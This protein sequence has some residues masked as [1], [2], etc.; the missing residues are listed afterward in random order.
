MTPENRKKVPLSFLLASHRSGTTLLR[1]C[2]GSHSKIE[3]LD[4]VFVGYRQQP[5][6]FF[7]FHKVLVKK[8]ANWAIPE[9]ESQKRLYHEYTSY[10]RGLYNPGSNLIVDVKYSHAHRLN[11]I[12]HRPFDVPNLL[13]MVMNSEALIIHLVRKN[14]LEAHI[15][16][17]VAKKNGSFRAKNRSEVADPVVSV[18]CTV[19]LADLER[20]QKEI[21]FFDDI[22]RDYP[23]TLR[24]EYGDL[25]G[26]DGDI[27]ISIV[28]EISSSLGLD[29]EFDRTPARQ[30]LALPLED[31]ITNYDA[32]RTTLLGT[33]YAWML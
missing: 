4:E 27:D 31:S 20:R 26:P 12:N 1:E 6:N 30:K 17:L 19:L 2:L 15:S 18:D 5:K 33:Q 9:D 25:I 22:L 29:V 10:L 11:K 21:E 14:I 13:S 24:Y 16:S 3:S 8:D 32:V 23:R 7:K 28:T